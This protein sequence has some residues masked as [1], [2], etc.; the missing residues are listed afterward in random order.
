MRLPCFKKRQAFPPSAEN[1]CICHIAWGHLEQVLA[2]ATRN[3]G[4]KSAFVKYPAL[5]SLICV[6]AAP[7]MSVSLQSQD[8][9]IAGL[10]LSAQKKID[11]VTGVSL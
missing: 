9:K 6:P 5:L 11:S 4:S 3:E 1:A 10:V 8:L 7:K 2:N